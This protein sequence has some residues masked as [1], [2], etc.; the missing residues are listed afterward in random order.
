M[1]PAKLPTSKPHQQPTPLAK[2]TASTALWT[3]WADAT[4]AMKGPAGDTAHARFP[5][6]HSVL[7]HIGVG[8]TTIRAYRCRYP[9]NCSVKRNICACTVGFDHSEERMFGRMVEKPGLTAPDRSLPKACMC[10]QLKMSWRRSSTG[11]STLDGQCGLP[12][13]PDAVHRLR[14]HHH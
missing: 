6:A 9:L 7:W 3:C 4:P 11:S 12:D 1:S 14:R 2:R 10:H 8:A 5:A 13:M